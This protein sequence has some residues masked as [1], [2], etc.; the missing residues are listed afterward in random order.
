MKK[1]LKIT[2]ITILGLLTI[3][4]TGIA[5]VTRV[6]SCDTTRDYDYYLR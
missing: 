6:L 3:T 5:I 4:V 1:S 2:L